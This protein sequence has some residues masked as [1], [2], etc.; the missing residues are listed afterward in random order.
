MKFRE[1]TG[2][3]K[4]L[5]RVVEDANNDGPQAIMRHGEVIAVIL[6]MTEYRDLLATRGWAADDDVQ[7][8]LRQA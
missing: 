7:S 6:S 1:F 5:G 2:V 4:Y 3:K 8:K